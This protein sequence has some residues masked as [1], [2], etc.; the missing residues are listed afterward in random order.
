MCQPLWSWVATGSMAAGALFLL[1]A[2]WKLIDYSLKYRAALRA[3]DYR[4]QVAPEETMRKHRWTGDDNLLQGSADADVA[5][6]IREELD[7]RKL[8]P[9]PKS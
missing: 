6:K 3:E 4:Q 1:W 9:G 2:T 5:A 7:R 8:Q